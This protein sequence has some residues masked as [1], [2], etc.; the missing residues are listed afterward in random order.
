MQLVTDDGLLF[1]GLWRMLSMLATT[2][3]WNDQVLAPPAQVAYSSQVL[4]MLPRCM[5][6]G[7]RQRPASEQHL[8]AGGHACLQ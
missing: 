4:R 1:Y 3:M 8:P 2:S 7:T 5:S 6:G